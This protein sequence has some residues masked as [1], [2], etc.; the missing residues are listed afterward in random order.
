M[1][2]LRKLDCYSEGS[3]LILTS[4]I[5]QPIVDEMMKVIDY[6][7]NMMNHEGVIVA[8]GDPERIHQI[9]QGALEA[10]ELRRE[11]II[12][13]TDFRNMQGT[14]KGVNVPIEIED[15][16]VGVVGITGEPTKIYKYIHIIKITV[17]TLLEQQLLME[18]LRYKQTTL[19]EW[20]NHLADTKY[21]NI[22]L[23][24]SKA[25]YLQIDLLKSCSVIAIEIKDFNKAILDYEMRYKNEIKIL[26]TLKL[27]FPQSLFSTYLGQGVFVVAQPLKNNPDVN[28]CMQTCQELNQTLENEGFV[29]YIGI[30]CKNKG[31]MGLRSSL[32]E[33]RQSIDILKQFESGESVAHITEWGSIQLLAF[34]PANL[35]KSYLAQFFHQKPSLPPELKETLRFYLENDL[36]NKIT[37]EMMHIHRN[38]L[39][40]RL[41]KIKEL[42]GLDPRK[43]RDAVKL[44]LVFWCEKL[45]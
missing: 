31:I 4:A 35:R 39:I 21:N 26:K 5:A 8:S 33:A 17:E 29:N 43:F 45:K 2:L 7:V 20:V 30:G 15:N 38:T 36:N 3:R 41:D 23:L 6:N 22:S 34:I 12:H 25:N 19:E 14:N 28:L 32:V 9:H 11:R 1:L 16:I 37:S 44:Q 10:I 18:Q 42:W 40:Y 27:Y 24:E 13:Q